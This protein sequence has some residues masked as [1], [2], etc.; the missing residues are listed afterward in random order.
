MRPNWF[1]ALPVPA[2]PWFRER[3]AAQPP[4]SVRLF[5]PDDLHLTIAFLGSVEESAAR[6]AWE[7]AS[8]W[9]QG[10]VSVSFGEVVGMGPPAEFSALSALL[11]SG[12]AEVEEGMRACRD[13]MIAAASARPELH[14]I[15]AHVTLGR[16][17]RDARQSGRNAALAWALRLPLRDLTVE[18]SEIALYTWPEDRRERQFRT[19]E[20]LR[21][22]S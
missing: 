9:R 16:P 8:L 13:P 10:A 11:E 2:E 15:K 5:H 20:R 14:P 19:V 17:R 1:I 7:L 6:R 4:P 18:L 12:R 22:P 21:L 3:V